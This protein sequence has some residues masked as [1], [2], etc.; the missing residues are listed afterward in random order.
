MYIQ[1]ELQVNKKEKKVIILILILAII[2]L[3]S[4]IITSTVK[5]T[6]KLSKITDL[7]TLRALSYGQ[8]TDNDTYVEGCKNLE[9][10]AFF[11][12]DLDGDGN[13]EKMKGTSK[14]IN[15]SDKLYID[16]NALAGGRLE[17]G[18]ITI[19]G[20]NFNY[21]L[22]M[23][24]DSVLKYSYISNNVR[25][26]SLNNLESGTQ[27]LIY[28]D[29]LANIGSDTNNYTRTDNTVTLKGVYVAEGGTKT[30]VNK[31]INIAV[32][33][34]GTTN[35]SI[36]KQYFSFNYADLKDNDLKFDLKTNELANQ[37]LLKETGVTLT[38]PIKQ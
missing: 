37:L 31:T 8:I 17:N 7:E 26:I 15:G 27:K 21:S 38:K 19:N 16:L 28:G 34:Y 29:I 10:S 1:W 36:E 4:V 22:N 24:K 32:D 5:T 25:A 33:W 12:R 14:Y 9:F 23:V 18:E 35:T 30:N 3:C 20:N 6:N 11:T 13:A 2:T